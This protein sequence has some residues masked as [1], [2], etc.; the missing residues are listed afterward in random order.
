M[1]TRK[2]VQW[3]DVSGLEPAKKALKEIIVLPFLRPYVFK[4]FYTA[5]IIYTAL[6]ITLHFLYISFGNWDVYAKLC[7]GF[8][9]STCNCIKLIIL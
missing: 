2:D 1:S 4:L 8:N 6:L 9:F 5:D 3:A 7:Q